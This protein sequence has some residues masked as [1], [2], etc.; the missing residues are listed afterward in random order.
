MTTTHPLFVAAENDYRLAQA[1]KMYGTP[2][3]GRR[4][5]VRRL[6]TLHLPRRLRRPLSLA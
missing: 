5:S 3:P 4:H 2:S 1:R 6:P